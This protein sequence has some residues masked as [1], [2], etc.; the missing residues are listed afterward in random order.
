MKA[1]YTILLGLLISLA[2]LF[3]M[4]AAEEKGDANAIGMYFVVFLVPVIIIALFNGI[5][6][7]SLNYQ[8]NRNSKIILSFIP[9]LFLIILSQMKNLQ[10]NFIDGS[11]SFV[12]LVGAIGIGLTNIIWVL[13]LF[14]ND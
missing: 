5:F 14:R 6:I 7:S 8:K 13:C 9:L 1:K 12:G 11:I 4:A 2:T 10:I 3:I